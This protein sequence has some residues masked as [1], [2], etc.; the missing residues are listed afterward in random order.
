MKKATSAFYS[1]AILAWACL[2]SP[3]L[4]AAPTGENSMNVSPTM[5]NLEPG[6]AGLLTVSNNGPQPINVQIE[7]FAWTQTEQ[8]QQIS[9]TR[10]I[11]VSPPMTTVNAS[12]SQLIRI[13]AL[14]GEKPLPEETYRVI[15]SQLPTE[16]DKR[17][18]QVQLLLQFSVPVFVSTLPPQ[19]PAVQWNITRSSTSARLSIRNSGVR[20][21]RLSR[22]KLTRENGTPVPFQSDRITYLSPGMTQSVDLPPDAVMAG[23][24]LRIEGM[25]TRSQKTLSSDITVQKQ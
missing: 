9:D 2:Q 25:D 18:N 6:E 4:H 23:A 24:K 7:G 19:D 3:A 10:R 11:V 17:T 12:D 8:G 15:V 13:I 16:E 14:P 22:L 20:Y 21:I 1:L 5:L